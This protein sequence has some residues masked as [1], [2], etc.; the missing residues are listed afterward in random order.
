MKNIILISLLFSFNLKYVERIVFGG[1]KLT[2]EE[3]TRILGEPCQLKESQST[4]K[5]GGH[6]YKSTYLAHSSGE[7]PDK[8]VA[9]Y[10]VFE[11]YANEVEAKTTF[12]TF[13]PSNQNNEGFEMMS[14]L[15][16]DAFFQTDK[17]NFCLIIVCKGNEIV[18]FKVNK[19]TSKTSLTEL[20]QIANDLVS[21][22]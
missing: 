14:N 6:Q 8:I 11:S 5:N 3:A 1:H 7:T 20:K 19:M 13:K 2:I 4:A 9:L 17:H 16:N 12:D 15:G 21:R 10:F 22:V 18:R